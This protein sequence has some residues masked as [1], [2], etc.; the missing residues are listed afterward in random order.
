MALDIFQQLV[1]IAVRFTSLKR[2]LT[3]PPLKGVRGM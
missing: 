1:N 2:E 3:F